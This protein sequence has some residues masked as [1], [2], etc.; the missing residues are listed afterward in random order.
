MA[1]MTKEK[2]LGIKN[3]IVAA[4]TANQLKDIVN[5]AATN[6]TAPP[7]QKATAAHN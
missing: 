5:V 7:S 3:V 4:I 1:I 6:A 2:V